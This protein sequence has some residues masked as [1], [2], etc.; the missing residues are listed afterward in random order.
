MP[1]K[2]KRRQ[3][4]YRVLKRKWFKPAL[5]TLGMSM[6]IYIC[7]SSFIIQR[8]VVEHHR[9][10]FLISRLSDKFD[11]IEF[12]HLLLTIQELKSIP[13]ASVQLI[14]Y[15]NGPYPGECPR[16]LTRQ[17]NNMNWQPQAFLIR[18]KKIFQMHEA[19]THIQRLDTAITYL[20]EEY[21]NKRL[22]RDTRNQ[23]DLL[24]AERDNLKQREFSPQSYEF[25][26]K[27]A[28]LVQ[29]ILKLN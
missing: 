29:T 14:D 2:I 15:A 20:E 12:M 3:K 6:L 13:V 21:E 17:L 9:P 8:K 28:G 5:Y 19:Y 26:A 11:E 7:I 18:L 27:Y 24:I 22:P 25:I 10:H 23:I 16:Y 1:K 4:L